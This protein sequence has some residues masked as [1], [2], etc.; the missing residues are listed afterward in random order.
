MDALASAVHREGRVGGG[1]S[2]SGARE[3]EGV[4]MVDEAEDFAPSWR[5]STADPRTS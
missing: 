3:I 4:A 5:G 2:G 1:K